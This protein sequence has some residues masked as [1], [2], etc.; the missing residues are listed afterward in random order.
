MR[1]EHKWLSSYHHLVL[2]GNLY[3]WIYPFVCECGA[4]KKHDGTILEPTVTEEL[5]KEIDMGPRK[6]EEL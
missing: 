4:L 5:Q 3:R 1:H 6:A 2:V